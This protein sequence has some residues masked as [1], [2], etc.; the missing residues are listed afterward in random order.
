MSLLELIAAVFALCGLVYYVLCAAA[1]LSFARKRLPSTLFTPPVTIL[2]PLRGADPH[3]YEC[4]RSQCV[5]EYP[6]YEVLFGVNDSADPAAAVVERLSQE[7]PYVRLFVC[8]EIFGPNRKV[9]TLAQM[10][11]H[12]RYDHLVISDSDI[13]VAPDYL[14]HVIAPLAD[15]TVGL[16]TSL[17]RGVSGRS[18]WSEV[19]ALGIVDFTASVLLAYR[20]NFHYGFGSTLALSRETLD[21]IGGLEQFAGYLADDYQLATA[22]ARLGKKVVIAPGAVATLLPDYSFAQFWAHQQRWARTVRDANTAGYFGLLLTFGIVWSVVAV[23]ASHGAAWAWTLLIANALLRGF[24][25]VLIEMSVLKDRRASYNLTL[26]LR[27]LLE[28]LVWAA[29]WLGNTVTWRGEKF[30]LWKGKLGPIKRSL[31]IE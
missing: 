14:R 19:E 13:L 10:L 17:Y 26:P 1:A 6:E 2:K 7:Y 23:I 15:N 12:A 21:R 8:P 16:V 31:T 28:P 9:G 27:V 5:Q 20:G 29:S 4:F 3:A 11:R 22:V 18:I 25:T 24:V 30:R